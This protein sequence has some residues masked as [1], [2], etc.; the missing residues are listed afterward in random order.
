MFKAMFFCMLSAGVTSGAVLYVSQDGN[1]ANMG[2]R[3]RPL[4]TIQ[5]AVERLQ[6]GDTC[7]VRGGVYRET[8]VFPRSGEAGRPITLRAYRGERPVVSGCEPVTGWAPFSNGIWRAAMPWT[9]GTGRNQVFCGGQVMV[10]ARHPNVAAPGLELPVE[11][12]SPLWPSYGVFSIPKETRVSQPGRI[13][14]PLLKGQPPDYWKGALYVGV[15]FEGWCAQTG[16]IESSGDGEIQVGDRTQGWWFGSAYDGRYPQDHEE[17]RGMLVGHR[18]ALDV[19]GEWHW[20]EDALYL[21]PPDGLAPQAVEAKRRQLAFDL[22]GR[23]HIRIEGLTVQAASMRLEQAESCTV[24]GCGLSFISHYTRHYGIG[25]VERGRDTVRSGETGLFISGRGNAFLNCTVRHSAG[26]GFH[27][28]GYGHTIHNCLIDETSYVGHYLNAITDAVTDFNDYENLLV[29]GHTLTFNTMCNAGR[30]FFNFY[31]NGTSMASRDRGPM[32]YAAT[33]FAHNHLYNGMLLTRDAGFLTG[34]FGSGGTLNGQRS[35]VAYNV[36]HD[37][38][39]LAAIRWN[40]LGMVYLDQ[41]TCDVDVRNNLF[42]AAP[43]AL[44]RDLWFNT[45][46][47]RV[48]ERDNVFHGLFTRTCAELRPEDFPGRAPFRFGHDFEAPPRAPAWPRLDSCT[49]H[50]ETVELRAGDCLALGTVRA[51]GWASAVMRFASDVKT[52]NTERAARTQPRHRHSTDPLVLEAKVNDGTSEGL[53]LQWTFYH[54]M[55]DASWIRYSGVTLGDGFSRI[56]VVY[57]NDRP[58]ARLLELRLDRV[59][60]PL[61]AEV[62]LPQTDRSRPGHVQIYGEA[63]APVS[64]EARGTRDVYAVFRSAG[65]APSLDFEYLRLEQARGELPLQRDE[66]RLE[67]RAG[68]R[69][70]PKLG[71]FYPR[72]TGGSDNFREL[73]ARLEAGPSV[74]QPL[75]LVVRSAVEGRIGTMSGL[76]LERAAEGGLLEGPGEPPRRALLGLGGVVL[77]QVTHRPRQAAAHA[78]SFAGR[79]LW[80]A[81]LMEVPPKVDGRPDEWT[82]AKVALSN[83]REGAVPESLAPH[84][85]FASDAGTLYVAARVPPVGPHAV[86]DRIELALQRAEGGAPTLTLRGTADGRWCAADVAGVSEEARKRLA[87]ATMFRTCRGDGAWSCEW[88]IPLDVFGSQRPWLVNANVSVDGTGEDVFRAWRMSGGGAAYDLSLN[89]GTLILGSGVELPAEL[90]KGLAAWF[91]ASVEASV[92]R[93]TAGHVRLWRD[94]SG[95]GRDAA[96]DDERFRPVYEASALNGKPALRFRDMQRQRLEVPDLAEEQTAVTVF[97]VISNPEPGLADNHNPRIFT[98]S[99]GRQYDYQCGICCSIPGTQTGGPRLV[100]FSGKERWAKKARIGC[101][102]P[103]EQ[104]FLNGQ[105]SEILVLLREV[106]PEEHFR[107]SAYLTGKWGL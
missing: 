84:V 103:N 26:A 49:V 34:Y 76:R 5:A 105:I 24:D 73:V 32:D 98:A 52:L 67:L 77:P 31:G 90:R 51:D 36:M 70:G 92:S 69:E 45:C 107:I 56:R 25:Q 13:V 59:D 64:A 85:W 54:N 65:G 35:Q 81:A 4:A 106:S 6:P 60:G 22:S 53:R 44:Q 37:C 38:Y 29:G 3:A 57:G 101:F 12:L 9:L 96:Q 88:R 16:V 72:Q 15:H 23:A 91:D 82:G 95:N 46:C 14:S 89:G 93:D 71:Q 8:V 40:K 61:V 2:T 102:S 63:I 11:G 66:V 17:G 75:M 86:A 58:E 21:I 30:H 27:L 87:R 41:G 100:V 68:S 74:P 62:K 1:D 55:G 80:R 79:P 19:P 47:V 42:W 10:E 78:P 7:V 48:S 104:T 50:S 97:A 99:D 39:D 43:G 18:H 33:L 83:T 28:R 20:Q 94:R